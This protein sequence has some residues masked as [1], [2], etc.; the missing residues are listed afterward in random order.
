MGRPKGSK[1]RTTIERETKEAAAKKASRARK[2][3][4]YKLAKAESRALT[5]GRKKHFAQPLVQAAPPVVPTL[6]LTEVQETAKE[7]LA[8]AQAAATSVSTLLQVER[9]KFLDGWRQYIEYMLKTDKTPTVETYMQLFTHT[10]EA[11]GITAD[12]LAPYLPVEY[13]PVINSV[14][15]AQQFDS[16]TANADSLA[17]ANDGV[18]SIDLL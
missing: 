17:H 8:V 9:S 14:T 5:R 12:V 13:E 11:L 3:Q 1:N 18:S 2:R 16:I 15:L 10:V 6:H 4:E 7:A